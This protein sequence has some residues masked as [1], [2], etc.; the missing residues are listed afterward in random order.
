[1]ETNRQERQGRKGKKEEKDIEILQMIYDC[2]RDVIRTYAKILS[3]PLNFVSFA[4]F[5]VRFFMILRKS[6]LYVTSLQYYKN[7]QNA[8]FLKKIN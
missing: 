8:I 3:N 5:A 7:M 1:M 6:W 4:P 2:Y